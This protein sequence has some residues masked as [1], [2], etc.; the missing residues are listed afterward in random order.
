MQQQIQASQDLSNQAMYQLQNMGVDTSQMTQFQ[1]YTAPQSSQQAAAA[2]AATSPQFNFGGGGTSDP[3]YGAATTGSSTGGLNVSSL[4]GLLGGLPQPPNLS[5]Q[6]PTIGTD[7]AFANMPGGVPTRLN[8]A[9]V[10]TDQQMN[11][12]LNQAT[13]NNA[14]QAATQQEAAREAMTGNGFSAGSGAL[15]DVNRLIDAQRMNADTQAYSQIP[16]NAAQLNNQSMLQ[17]MGLNLQGQQ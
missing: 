17:Q 13:S 15:G 6:M 3:G 2:P 5:M 10:I 4:L 9:P 12:M 8:P 1:P 16:L 14:R 7:G 11:Q